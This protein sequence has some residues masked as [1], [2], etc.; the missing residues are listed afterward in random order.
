MYTFGYVFGISRHKFEKFITSQ[1]DDRMID[2]IPRG[3]KPQDAPVN[4]DGFANAQNT[5]DAWRKRLCYQATTEARKLA[6]DFKVELHK[7]EPEWADVLVPNCIYRGGCSE[8]SMCKECFF[9]NFLKYCNEN[10]INLYNIQARY[11]AYNDLFYKRKG[12][13]NNDK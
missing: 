13:E 5:I 7:F 12:Q 1:R 10:N 8:F 4:Y 11:D 6:E 3:K 2:E 9:G